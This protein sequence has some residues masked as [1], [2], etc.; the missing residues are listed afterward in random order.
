[1]Q[2]KH[3]LL[4]IFVL[5][6]RCQYATHSPWENRSNY[7]FA[8][9]WLPHCPACRCTISRMLTSDVERLRDGKNTIIRPQTLKDRSHT[10]SGRLSAQDWMRAP[11]SSAWHR[12]CCIMTSSPW[13]RSGWDGTATRVEALV[14]S[15]EPAVSDNCWW[16][17][18]INYF[19][20]N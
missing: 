14:W 7:T 1:M 12:P 15:D 8:P 4:F 17:N 11:E 13:Q 5:L 18:W 2:T 3:A 10:L 20:F 16:N 19:I 9:I 6:L